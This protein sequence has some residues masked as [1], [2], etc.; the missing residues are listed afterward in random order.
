MNILVIDTATSV[1]ITAASNGSLVSDQTRTVTESHS[2]TLFDS[3][4]LAL[5][6]AGLVVKDLD[7]IAAGIGPGSFTGIRIAVTTARMFAQ[8]FGLPLAGI[9]THLMYAV[10]AGGSLNAGENILIAFDAKKSRVFGALYA[11][12]GN[13][14]EPV[15][16]IQPGDYHIEY[17]LK[18]INTKEKTVLI[19]DGCEK[20][21]SEIKSGIQNQELL[22][23]YK[24][25][26]KMICRLV[27]KIYSG[28]PDNN[29][30]NKV[31]PFYARKTDAEIV[32]ESSKSREG[33][34]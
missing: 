34:L 18:H 31:L 33:I 20:Y 5:K 12:S 28:N 16:I 23:D 21:Y 7:L 14:L 24:P 3:I 29:D 19:G 25:S 26:G 22:A 32:K 15:E 8:L 11:K 2:V 6:G 4:D 1:E 13:E 27:E 10:S 30:L 9:K 17:L